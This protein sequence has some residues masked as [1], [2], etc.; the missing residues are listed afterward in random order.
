M[1]LLL[2]KAEIKSVIEGNLEFTEGDIDVQ[3]LETMHPMLKEAMAE[4]VVENIDSDAVLGAAAAFLK[5]YEKN[6]AE[7][8]VLDLQRQAIKQKEASSPTGQASTAAQEIRNKQLFL[9]KDFYSKAFAFD[10]ELSKFLYGDKFPKKGLYILEDSNTGTLETYELNMEQMLELINADARFKVDNRDVLNQQI[11]VAAL[12]NKKKE[13]K[14]W[15]GRVTV[16]RTA[17]KAASNRLERCYEVRQRW[18]EKGKLGEKGFDSAGKV[19]KLQRQ[20]GYLLWKKGRNWNWI[21]ITNA[22]DLKEGYAA[23]LFDSHAENLLPLRPHLGKAPYYSHD[24]VDKYVEYIQG[25]SNKAAILEEDI[26]TENGQYGVKT[27]NAALP[28]INQYVDSA[29]I[30]Q[31]FF[32]RKQYAKDKIASIISVLYDQDAKRNI[33]KIVDKDVLKFIQH[34]TKNTFKETSS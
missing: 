1:L 29:K 10:D 15:Q 9:L 7:I 21:Q 33:K 12:E 24:L 30:V 13:D 5:A 19:K 25:V 4:E 22:G 26:V 3:G 28:T 27:L 32:S 34:L 18:Y 20:G 6:I 16:A 14:E 17:Y 2:L 31:Y 23:M 11:G 8:E